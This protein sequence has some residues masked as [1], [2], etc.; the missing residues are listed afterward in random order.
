MIFR[1]NI[2][3]KNTFIYAFTEGVNKAI[4]FFLLPFLTKVLQPESYGLLSN[5]NTLM[6]L[7]IVFVTLST[8]GALSIQYFKLP[9]KQ[10]PHYIT[11]LLYVV[12][13][14]AMFVLLSVLSLKGPI[15]EATKLSINWQIVALFSAIGFT[16]N[17]L[18]LSLYRV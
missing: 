3:I 5:F 14:G 6:Q 4:P 15:F 16:I 13:I 17:S 7:S 12:L 1:N 8:P 18:N 9:A 11:N 2:V 10:V